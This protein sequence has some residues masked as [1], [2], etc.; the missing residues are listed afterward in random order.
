MSGPSPSLPHDDTAG[1]PAPLLRLEDLSVTFR[2]DAGSLH[3][4]RNVNLSLPDGG[5]TCLVGE[6]GCGK[7]LTA[8]AV[9]RLLPDNAVLNGRVL[10]R[11]VNL[12]D[13]PEK[14]MRTVR[15]RQIGMIFQEPMTS[16]N[17]VL[18]IG[19]Q[20]AEPLRLHLKLS[21]SQARR[22]VASLLADVGIPSPAQRYGDYPHQLSGGMRQRVMIAMA[23]ACGPDILLADEPTTALD[24]TIQGQI[25]RLLEN[26]RQKRGMAVLLIT[27]DLHVAAQTAD[28][29]GVMYAGRL[30]E[31]GPARELFARP[32]HPYTR[33]LLQAAPGFAARSLSRLP[34][35]AGSVPPLGKM[36]GGCPFHPRC[37]KALDQCT[38]AMPPA[39]TAGPHSV[40]C[41][42]EVAPTGGA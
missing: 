38:Q 32:R 30:V 15:G 22:E 25:L 8:R 1:H 13:L 33:G 19:E 3:A 39:S 4:V 26:L 31:Y 17:P 28:T 16:L 9:L 10:L 34:A 27:H 29:V 35:I 23:L 21:R 24:A 5:I 41:W 6:S 12:P 14:A 36:P 2:T 42:R 20:V 11:G 37:S 40:A 18:T 7:S